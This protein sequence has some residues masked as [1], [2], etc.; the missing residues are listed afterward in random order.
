MKSMADYFSEFE[1]T[2][3]TK[4]YIDR[5]TPIDIFY[6]RDDA[7]RL[8][9]ALTST[10]SV[11]VPKNTK[12]LDFIQVK[13]QE[14]YWTYIC[15]NDE[16]A[17]SVFYAFC[18]DVIDIVANSSDDRTAIKNAIDRIM[19]WKRMF[20]SRTGLLTENE[21]KGIFGELYF[22]D[23]VIIPDIGCEKGV[24]AWG[25]PLGLSKD[26][27]NGL[28]WY[29]VKTVSANVCSV[30]ISS[31]EQLLSNN[32]GYLVLIRVEAMPEGFNNGIAT[33]NDLFDKLKNE[34]RT[35]PEASDEFFNRLSKIGF[36]PEDAYNHYRY[37]VVSMTAY[38]VDDKFPKITSP[39]K[40]GEAFSKISY[41]LLINAIAPYEEEK[42][43]TKKD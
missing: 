39:T 33:I 31:H 16:S 4:L 36:A 26:F 18:Q 14:K 15:L 32:P 41:S 1:D 7:G 37:K 43:W 10:F 5:P 9:I 8:C 13:N 38:L 11:K 24:K 25:G 3:R 23:N 27:S 40:F 29:E 12:T 2:N 28:E 30:N 35:F 19:S 17:K 34:L 6:G 20:S 22:L 21:I 42:T